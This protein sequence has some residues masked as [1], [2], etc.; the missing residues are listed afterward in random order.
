MA[1][2]L[3]EA[4]GA[5]LEFALSFGPRWMRFGCATLLGLVVVGLLLWALWPWR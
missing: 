3:A 4:I 1:E 2:V 5:L